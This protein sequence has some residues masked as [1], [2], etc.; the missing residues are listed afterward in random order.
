MSLSL[1]ESVSYLFQACKGQMQ[2]WNRSETIEDWLQ[3]PEL[4]RRL[5]NKTK[6]LLS[7]IPNL[8]K[9]GERYGLKETSNYKKFVLLDRDAVVYSVSACE[10]LSF[11]VKKWNFP[12]LGSVP[13]LGFFNKE[14]AIEY[15]K[16]IK[17]ESAIEEKNQ[18]DIDVRPVSAYST[19]GWFSDPLLSSMLRKGEDALGELV[20][21]VLHESTHAT[22]YIS[23]QTAFNESL[24]SFVGETLALMYLKETRGENSI[25]YQSYYEGIQFGQKIAN[26]FSLNAKKLK[27]IYDSSLSDEI[28]RFK[29]SEILISLQETFKLKRALN[30]ASLSQYLTYSEGTV[31]FKNYFEKKCKSDFIKFFKSLSKLKDQNF[32]EKQSSD[33]SDV[34]ESVECI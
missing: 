22:L 10:P 16:K 21:V 30:N 14:N 12:I 34:L 33:F 23:N 20:E 13:Y 25:E 17:S 27:E 29:K 28:K 4:S 11:Q 1:N 24:A 15:S 31:P 7:E 8:K 19:L 26:A 18:L 6:L 5:D 2:L 32:K 3:K 9:F